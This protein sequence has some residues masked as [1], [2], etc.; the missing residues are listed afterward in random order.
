MS[1]VEKIAIE[2][3]SAVAA[4]YRSATPIER[5]QL[6]TRIGLILRVSTGDK[7]EA[8][9]R[10]KQTMDTIG[11]EAVANGLTPEILEL[12]LND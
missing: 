9:A 10:L 3:P 2:V 1:T 4:A 7:Q 12:I 5:Q 6:A 8:V 11:N